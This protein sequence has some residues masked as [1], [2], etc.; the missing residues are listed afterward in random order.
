MSDHDDP[1]DIVERLLAEQQMK[2]HEL[3]ELVGEYRRLI[4]D[5]REQP[6]IDRVRLARGLPGTRYRI[7]IEYIRQNWLKLEVELARAFDAPK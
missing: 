1:F 5:V 6:T 2:L 4:A 3:G 7:N